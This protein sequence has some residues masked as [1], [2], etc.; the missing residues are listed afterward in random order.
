MK[1]DICVTVTKE[2]EELKDK[3]PDETLENIKALVGLYW[4]KGLKKV[5]EYPT[6]SELRSF[7]D[8]LR[9][10]PDITNG[11]KQSETQEVKIINPYA[12]NIEVKLTYS[13]EGADAKGMGAVYVVR[14]NG[15]YIGKFPIDAYYRS[16]DMFEVWGEDD[17]TVSASS[18]GNRVELDKEF[19]SKGLGKAMYYAVGTEI[20]K[21]NKVL[22]SSSSNVR[23]EA[24]TRV[25][26]S[27][28][29]DGYARKV[30]NYYEF[31]GLT[32]SS[33]NADKSI[34]SNKFNPNKIN[35]PLIR[36][37][38]I[39][40]EDIRKV[41]T[42]Y[43]AYTRRDRV[44]LITSLFSKRL[45]EALEQKKE[46]LNDRLSDPDISSWR[47]R[48]I[49]EALN[50]LDK[51]QLLA[52]LTPKGV[53]DLV[54]K[55]FQ[56]YIDKT[57]EDR[58]KLELNAIN[59]VKGSEKIS[60]DKKKKVAEKR[61]QY[62]YVE[63]QKLLD[64]FNALAQE[65]CPSIS[66]REQVLIGSVDQLSKSITKEESWME[67]EDSMPEDSP[68]SITTKEEAPKDGW[69]R[70]FRTITS[71]ESLSKE[72]A[73]M[74]GNIIEVDYNGRPA[75]D[76]LGNQRR[77]DAG[78]VHVALM[79][80]LSK[81]T[82]S[83]DMVP[84]LQ[85]M[86]KY[87]PWVK[88]ILK[89]IQEDNS[90]FTKLYVDMRK[91]A[92]NYTVIIKEKNGDTYT[93]KTKKVNQMEPIM[94]LID[95]M[96]SNYESATPL[97]DDSIYNKDRTINLSNVDKG[98]DII[99]DLMKTFKGKTDSE[100]EEITGQDKGVL[101]NL[102][103]IL[104]MTGFD[105]TPEM[106]QFLAVPKSA[107][108]NSKDSKAY[109]IL[110]HLNSL[111]NAVKKEGDD[112][113]FN[114][115]SD[116]R[117]LLYQVAS[118]LEDVQEGFVEFTFRE[119]GKSYSSH[120]TPSFLGKLV[121][122]LKGVNG[123]IARAN[124]FTEREFGQYNWFKKGDRWL[125]SILRN[126]TE[127]PTDREEF[128][129]KVEL[130]M[131]RVEYMEWDS[132]D[133]MNVMLQNYFA[134][135]TEFGY[136]YVPILSDAPSAEFLRLRKI[137]NNTNT[138]PVTFEPL[139][140]KESIIRRL[141]DVVEQEYDRIQVVRERSVLIK[142]GKIKPIKSY[143]TKGKKFLF[144][145]ELNTYKDPETGKLFLDRLI[146][147]K[148]T[149]ATKLTKFLHDTLEII[150]DA[151]F[152]K[153]MGY[154]TENGLFDTTEDGRF[155]NLPTNISSDNTLEGWTSK[156]E[157][158]FWNN[159]Y[160]QSQIIQLT[161]GDLAFYK[162]ME[163]FQKRFKEF[164]SPAL[165]PNT[166]A[167]WNGELVGREFERV[168][169]LNDEYGISRSIDDIERVLNEKVVSKEMTSLDKDFILSQYKGVNIT[170]AQAFRSL[171]S[172]R[173]AMIMMGK[174]S[175]EAEISY[176]HLTKPAEYGEWNASDFYTIWQTIKP[177]MFS[178]VGVDS[179]V[180]DY[181]KIK[182]GVQHK[183]SEFL[184]LA[185]YDA[186]TSPLSTSPKLRAINKFMETH[187]IDVVM[188]NS[189]VKTGEQGT[190]DIGGL[191]SEKEIIEHLEKNTTLNGNENSEV[192]HSFPYD[193][194]GVQMSTPEHS[195]DVSIALGT[196][197]RKLI[198]ADFPNVVSIDI[199]VSPGNIVTKTK[200]E[201]LQL[202]S[203]LVTA[204]IV[205]QF[206]ELDN[207][208]NL[209]DEN[210]NISR[211]KLSELLQDEARGNTR[212]GQ[213]VVNACKLRPDGNFNIPLYEEIQSKRVQ[214]LINSIIR[215]R[216]TK[217]KIKGGACFQ[218]SNY[219]LT[220]DLHIEWTKD[221]GI[222]HLEC[223][224]P[225]YSR[226]FFEPLMKE[227]GS[228]DINKL[229]EELRRFVGYRVPTEDKYS[230]LPLY[231]KG[232]LPQQNGSSI[233]LPQEI[234]TITGSDFDI[235]KLYILLPEF[236]TS[237]KTDWR[238]LTKDI[239]HSNGFRNHRDKVGQVQAER[240]L[241][242]AIGVLQS[243]QKYS[244]DG[245]EAFIARYLK[246][247][248]DIYNTTTFSKVS[249][250]FDKTARE[251]S[252][253][254]RNNLFIDMV[255]SILS[256]KDTASKI[257]QPGGFEQLKRVD[258]LMRVLT[259]VPKNIVD[260]YCKSKNISYEQFT[261]LGIGEYEA[262]LEAYSNEIDPLSAVTQI[263]FH[264]KNTI[265]GKMIGVY[266]NHNVNHAIT[267]F[268]NTYVSKGGSFIFNAKALRSLHEIKNN[269]NET[270]SRNIA[271]WLAA[272]VD[273]VKDNT[274]DSTNQ[275]YF[276]GDV[277]MF[278]TRLG[279]R[280]HEVATLM[281]QP[282]VKWL[283][284]EW[285]RE[286]D[287]SR[288]KKDFIKSKLLSLKSNIE[289]D[290]KTIDGESF[291]L[292]ELIPDILGKA[293]IHSDRQIK[294]GLLFMK[295]MN[296]A[297]ALADMVRCSRV[298]VSNMAAGPT[299]A[300]TLVK[301]L[302]IRKLAKKASK[303]GF[304]IRDLS[305][306]I[307]ESNDFN[308]PTGYMQAFYKKGIEDVQELL[309]NHFPHF[310]T[311]FLDVIESLANESTSG[312]LNAK[313][314]NDIID[315][316]FAYI[317]SGT[318]F[319]GNDETMTS[320]NKREKY[321]NDFPKEFSKLKTSNPDIANNRLIKNLKVINGN[322]YSR[323]PY[324][325]FGNVGTLSQA[326]R[327]DMSN[328]WTALLYS[329]DPVANKLAL[330]LF[331]Y[332]YYRTG[333]AFGPDSFIHLA[334]NELKYN[335]PNYIETL[336]SLIGSWESY[337]G[338][339]EQY[340][341]NHSYNPK[342]VREI[343]EED[344]LSTEKED[345]DVVYSKEGKYITINF[346]FN[347]ES[348][349]NW[350]K[351][352][353]KDSSTEFTIPYTFIKVQTREG[354]K[355]FMRESI[356]KISDVTTNRFIWT[357]YEVTPLGRRNGFLEYER[358]NDNLESAIHEPK[359]MKTLTDGYVTGEDGETYDM[360]ID[361]GYVSDEN[362]SSNKETI[363]EAQSEAFKAI[364]G[365]EMPEGSSSEVNIKNLPMDKNFKDADNKPIC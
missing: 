211:E 139:S 165:K 114:M 91:D 320:Y 132:V 57:E 288:T 123:D 20:Q 47:K 261:T 77:L 212:Y 149:D 265:G 251:N 94:Y 85:E 333:F 203:D 18:I 96:R 188:F 143:D 95:D 1:R 253:A 359:A 155:K 107:N 227:D 144:I 339:E 35:K 208:F 309:K 117:N 148:E 157:E 307:P 354:E 22:K 226:Q 238:K 257:V 235:D 360:S 325:A 133:Y 231:I 9:N 278:L 32:E 266:A 336:E 159:T 52:E 177:Y 246:D 346:N 285:F 12:T 142:E 41:N 171:S 272:S 355:L 281:N 147:L 122:E 152:S 262:L 312:V 64:N 25:W 17:N 310:N 4:E 247:H 318:E 40:A 16:E 219:G 279:Y 151:K 190:L 215:N 353:I 10:K 120:V 242:I 56:D 189:A 298:D 14:H 88:Q 210:G 69:M 308:G 76:D 329:S 199:E 53:F 131:D 162:N 223:Y 352:L 232:F 302:R 49:A 193:D 141:Y 70:N 90:L 36:R 348:R 236:N 105:V 209:K 299:L 317:M 26:E 357:F 178:M 63:Y 93:T 248:S 72:V 185:I 239:R 228:L 86:A 197:M 344:L 78:R 116:T 38:G 101:N 33:K 252:K 350:I 183:N 48:D 136:F 73:A 80:Q 59:K 66:T 286:R 280:H 24:A 303:K 150:M 44:N 156:L 103:K 34:V 60:D 83:S 115:L 11:R 109:S 145:P 39:S 282:I 328:D 23:S 140:Y 42:V 284:R 45:T 164:H 62:K 172:Y 200:E 5:D 6:E 127:R 268:F 334:P 361:Y 184:L 167:T 119:A 135:N 304:P 121:K 79:H 311:G 216:V 222:K 182:V 13:P 224:M 55:G 186:I 174:W 97:D 112:K 163:D 358:G 270:I 342:F 153:A 207:I 28:V 65:A 283:T 237:T 275:N 134:D 305:M 269:Y 54:K 160:M 263:E 225:A 337:W 100:I 3:F 7:M 296:G 294:V 243:N 326:Q 51:Q 292:N 195:I 213:D 137:Q 161:A 102:G 204:S 331:L 108:P 306:P 258:R 158:F 315:N 175:D 81:M 274:L 2:L 173:R 126:L 240:D 362:E 181:G 205:E 330:D 347:V 363:K 260:D 349:Y 202:Y 234:T 87:K 250:N 74:F 130:N 289:I 187:D 220:D 273:N 277:T 15:R 170:D 316:L 351:P 256:H 124:Q 365:K 291:I 8:N 113:N 166:K 68:E 249:Y 293:D 314:I 264:R 37:E 206:D 343:K 43:N 104:R 201:W 230:I 31:I 345:P 191:H 229:P 276:T 254:A 255:N 301:L 46:S 233:M 332:S 146:E 335:V 29:K 340:I 176:N 179:H 319:F 321:I 323:V 341:R 290:E 84:L 324:I 82:K 50:N 71:R 99:S 19:R 287:F 297:E 322:K 180:G 295:M 67:D 313:D 267:Q 327:E 300:D 192:I 92:M 271:I 169:Y 196:Q 338:F 75:K 111:Y 106:I 356:E 110:G 214:M 364:L 138:D 259:E 221:G 154:W 194:W 89:T 61:A 198:P 125:N 241:E 30:N 27:L 128:T 129:W 244:E 58:V 218:V 98:L 245:L 217:Q 118:K 21:H 168:L